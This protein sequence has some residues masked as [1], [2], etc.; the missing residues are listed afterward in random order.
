MDLSEFKTIESGNVKDE[1]VLFIEELILTG[2]LKPEDRLPSERELAVHYG[3][4]RPVIHEGILTLENRGLVTLRSRHGVVVN[5]YRKE[6]TLE[7]LLSLLAGSRHDLGPGLHTDLE[8]FRVHMEKDIVSLICRRCGDAADELAELE[9]I[10][11]RMAA[12]Q[13]PA[14]LSEL[15][16]QF[17]LQMALLS[18][19]TLYALLTNTLKPAHTE[20]LTRF[21]QDEKIRD[22]VVFFHRQIIPAL[23]AGDEQAAEELIIK[24]DSYESYKD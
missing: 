8:H 21:Y 14:E 3:V 10:N 16:F 5:N 9:K 15:D 1:F 12:A 24:I 20:Y 6:A 17:H 18:R 2:Q 19:N 7:L 23:Q 22:K 4:S 13:N 11:D